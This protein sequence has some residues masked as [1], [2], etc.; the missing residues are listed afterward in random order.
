MTEV[1]RMTG[2]TKRFGS[3]T[4]LKDVDFDVRQGEVHALLGINGA[5]KSTLVKI[6]SGLYT[7]DAGVIEVDGVVQTI[8]SPR[9]AISCG[10]ATVQQHP[11]LV[12]D[13]TGYENIFLGQEGVRR[14]LFGQVDRPALRRRADELLK[15]FPIQIDLSQV[16]RDMEGVERE[17]VA[18]LHALKQDNTKLLIL[19]EPTS[20]LTHKEAENLFQVMATLKRSGIGIIY[21]THRI[22]EVYTVADRFTV[23]RDGLKIATLR[24]GEGSR[25]ETTISTLMLQE[26]LGELYPSRADAVAADV[27]PFLEA[28]HLTLNGAFRNLDLSLKPGEVLGGFGLVGSG[29][30]GLAMTLFGAQEPD[31]GDI[32]IDGEKVNLK[33]PKEALGRGIFL[34]PGDRKTEGLTLEQDLTFNAT[35]ANLQRASYPGGILRRGRNAE[36][37]SE[38]LDR[39]E[40]RPSQLWRR[41]GEFSGGNQQKVVLAK[42]LFRQA[43]IY[44]FVEPTVGV[45]I[46]ARSKIYTMIK[47]LSQSA[48]VLVL[49]SDFDEIYGVADR[50]FAM[51]RGELSVAPSREVSRDDLLTGGLM[52]AVQ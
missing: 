3:V 27:T 28:K 2:I 6:I 37:V 29:I 47:E 8:S 4:A 33:T 7:A 22:E 13:L 10:I 25:D 12:G 5:G 20:T 11:E 16:V 46:G 30:E 51:Y 9:H 44:I 24:T 18:I 35:L 41:A 38:V 43:R 14:G 17:T 45:D 26:D 34:V 32:L 52:G 15:R 31:S 36:Q 1:L 50:V 19:D 49:S 42:G 21:I 39:L 48:A 40:L 23:F